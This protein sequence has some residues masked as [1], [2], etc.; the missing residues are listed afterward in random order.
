MRKFPV[1]GDIRTNSAPASRESITNLK[2]IGGNLVASIDNPFTGTVLDFFGLSLV[3]EINAIEYLPQKLDDF[4]D[5]IAGVN[6]T[7]QLPD[8]LAI[9]RTITASGS[10]KWVWIACRAKRD[11]ITYSDTITGM[12]RNNIVTSRLQVPIK[13]NPAVLTPEEIEVDYSETVYFPWFG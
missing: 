13:V 8:G 12:P 11:S 9:A 1:I 7:D 3:T 6:I 4:I 5:S 2:V 10:S